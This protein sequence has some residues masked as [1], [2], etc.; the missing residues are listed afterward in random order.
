MASAYV[1]NGTVSPARGSTPEPLALRRGTRE[2]AT[3]QD[4]DREV[5]FAM[6]DS[7]M[8]EP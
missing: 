6:L 2:R 5:A 1:I 4:P 7:G 8:S 3:F